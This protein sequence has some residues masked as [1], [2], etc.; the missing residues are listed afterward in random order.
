[1]GSTVARHCEDRG[2]W[3]H[4]IIVGYGSDNHKGRIHKIKIMKT[5]CIIT[6]VERHMTATPMLV[7]DYLRKKMLK[8][9]RPQAEDKL[10]EII[11]YFSLLNQND[12]FNLEME[13]KT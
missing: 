3:M 10:N 2:W 11:D 4:G 1:M 13:E 7:D 5:E 6:M 9:N 12:N 8:A